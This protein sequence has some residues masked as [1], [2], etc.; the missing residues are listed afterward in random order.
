MSTI[1][2]ITIFGQIWAKI[3]K[4]CDFRASKWSK[5]SFVGWFHE[6]TTMP[7]VQHKY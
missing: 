4:K 7:D 2:I 6:T 5:I 3:A 1:Q